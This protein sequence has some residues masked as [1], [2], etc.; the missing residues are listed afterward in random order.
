MSR[1][2]LAAFLMWAAAAPALAEIIILY[3]SQANAA[4]PSIVMLAPNTPLV[5]GG[6]VLMPSIVM[7]TFGAS[8]SP[9]VRQQLQR[10]HAWSVYQD[11]NVNSGIGLVYGIP[12]VSAPLSPAEASVYGNVS[13]AQAFRQGYFK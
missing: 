12:G 11:G 2:S 9:T 13:R 5:S 1:L 10:S 6:G 3:G 8:S 7:N 4:M